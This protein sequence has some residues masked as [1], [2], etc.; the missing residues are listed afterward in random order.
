MS[1][2]EF[3]NK[4]NGKYVDYDGV[5][6]YQCWD[7]VA[8]Y[9]DDT[10]KVPVGVISAYVDAMLNSNSSFYKYFVEVSTSSMQQG[11]I[12]IWASAP[13]IA[14]F[15]NKTGSTNYWFSQ[16]ANAR[17]SG[18]YSNPSTTS[19][20]RAFR[21]KSAYIVPPNDKKKVAPTTQLGY[22]TVRRGENLWNI[23]KKLYKTINPIKISLRINEIVKL[24]NIKNKNLIWAGQKLKYRK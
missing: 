23:V 1:Y 18:V 10:L 5:Y 14:I 21:L 11:D 2:I 15:D 22:Y 6:G 9:F 17:P 7:L 20:F 4:Y 13:H 19:T 24:N 8:K 3:K 16:D 12:C